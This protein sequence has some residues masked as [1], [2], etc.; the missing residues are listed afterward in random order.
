M[1]K[2]TKTQEQEQIKVEQSKEK[3]REVLDVLRTKKVGEALDILVIAQKF[4]SNNATNRAKSLDL[5]DLD[6]DVK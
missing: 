6:L 5:K 3:V 2:K 4:I 1:G